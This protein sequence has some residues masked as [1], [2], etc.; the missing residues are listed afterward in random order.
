MS[1]ARNA[2]SP[3]LVSDGI[4]SAV[5]ASTSAP[6]SAPSARSHSG[7]AVLA[8]S[9]K[10]VVR[11]SSMSRCG[12]PDLPPVPAAHRVVPLAQPDAEQPDRDERDQQQDQDHR[13]RAERDGPQRVAGRVAPAVGVRATK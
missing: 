8:Y 11:A 12:G 6:M 5:D 2:P 1:S 13:Q 7:V 10:S 9:G 4:I 3:T